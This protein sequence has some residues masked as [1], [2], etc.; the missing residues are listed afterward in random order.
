MIFVDAD[1]LDI[2]A[3][4]NDD[5]F[6]STNRPSTSSANSSYVQNIISENNKKQSTTVNSA[7][8][9]PFQ[10]S[11]LEHTAADD[12]IDMQYDDGSS[13]IPAYTSTVNN[14]YATK[15]TIKNN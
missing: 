4:Y 11:L 15:S 8:K 9:S 12:D 2:D 7:R 1:I 14:T 5:F 6:E 13:E 10:G 3:Q